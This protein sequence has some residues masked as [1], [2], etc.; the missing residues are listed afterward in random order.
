MSYTIRFINSDKV[1][2]VIGEAESR[3]ECFGAIR[4]FLDE[5]N[6]GSYYTRYWN[7]NGRTIIDVGSHTEFFSI[8]PEF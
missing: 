7:R 4:S 3:E 2:R 1:E 8:E 5:R 6:F